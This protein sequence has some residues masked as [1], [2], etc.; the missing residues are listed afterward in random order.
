MAGDTQANALAGITRSYKVASA[1]GLLVIALALMAAT[2]TARVITRPIEMLTTT[3]AA[4]NAGNLN[5][6]AEPNGPAELVTLAEAFNTLT[7]R[8]RS[9]INNLQEQVAQRTAQLEARAE[10][11]ATLNRITQ[12]VSSV[13]DFRAALEIVEQEMVQL[14]DA[15]NSGIALLNEARTH[16]IVDVEYFRDEDK[17]RAV[18][19]VIPLVGN[20]SSTYVVETGRPLVVSQAQTST[21]TAPI[22]GILQTHQTRCLMIVPLLAR[23]RV[24]G[25]IGVATDQ[26]DREFTPAEVELAETIAGQ[27]AGVIEN[28]RLFE[29]ERSQARRQEALFR[30]SAELAAT[31]DETEVCRQVVNGLHDTLG[32]G[33]MAL[34]LRAENTGEFVLQA[35]DSLADAPPQLPPPR[36]ADQY[37]FQ[38]GQLHYIPNITQ[39]RGFL[40]LDAGAEVAVPLRIGNEVVGV[41]VVE[42]K[43]PYSF[44]QADF[45][46]LTAA[47][48]QAGLA[49]DK[50]RLLTAERQRADELARA[51]RAAETAN[52]AKSQFL[53]NMSH[54]L[55]TPLNGIL[56][57][58]QLL[59]REL[60][61]TEHQ[62]DSL[63]IVQRSGEHLLTLINDILDLSK[64][65][66]GKTDLE[67]ADFHFPAF[68]QDLTEF[69][70]LRAEQKGLSFAYLPFDFAQNRSLTTPLPTA[71]HADEKCL[72]QVLINLLGNA[73]KFTEYGNVTLKVGPAAAETQERRHGSGGLAARFRS[74]S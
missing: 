30:L 64:I 66:A 50:A 17:P 63:N 67:P 11:L 65:E 61:L 69:I 36:G 44:S 71:V 29:A 52:K 27:I 59:K 72:R 49:I 62:K 39:D 33:H 22:H 12:K 74:R 20:A 57:Y 23:G 15:Y 41:L 7:T 21:M 35:K 8:L 53:A 25:T 40:C 55:R 4:I 13:N 34:Y 16:L 38:N 26:A 19:I 2:A 10:Q 24:N 56:G 9:L 45:E 58:T 18:N 68:L 54:E 6:R 32:Y 48:N 42:S 31:L 60:G 47:A 43:Q 5:Q 70:H 3:A 73:V 14:F 51:T 28:A 37:P 1:V 46:V